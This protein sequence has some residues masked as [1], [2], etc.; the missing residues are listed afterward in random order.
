ML[1]DPRYI[2]NELLLKIAASDEKA[3]ATFIAEHWKNIYGL[4]LA[5]LKSVEEAEELSQDI[6]V[7]LWKSRDKLPELRDIKNYLFIIAR[8]T[9]V[10]KI[11]SKLQD[12]GYVSNQKEEDHYWR[13]DRLMENKEAYAILLEGIAL[14]PPKRQQIFRMSRLEGLPYPEIARQ[15]NMN[16]DTVKQYIAKATV[17]LKAHMR[18]RMTDQ[19]MLLILFA[20]LF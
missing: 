10:S 15:L 20:E 4:A 6:F 16:K 3:F 5:W 18:E 7:K 19:C 11:R 2:E 1:P 9:M 8:N 17:F 14:L 13:P 12:P